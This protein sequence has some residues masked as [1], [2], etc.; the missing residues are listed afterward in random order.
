MMLVVSMPFQENI[1]MTYIAGVIGATTLEYVTVLRW[2]R[3][4]KSDIGITLIN[5][6]IFKGIY[7]YLLLWHGAF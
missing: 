4:L 1:F 2:R 3:S 6:L 7:V 5:G